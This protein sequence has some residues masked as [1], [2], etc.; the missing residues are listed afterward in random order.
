MR[1]YIATVILA[2]IA[3]AVVHRLF[4]AAADRYTII[5]VA[6]FAWSAWRV[7][8]AKRCAFRRV[9]AHLRSCDSAERDELLA[10]IEDLEL[11]AAARR[12]LNREHVETRNGS[13]EVFPFPRLFRTRATLRYWR[14]WGLSAAVLLIGAFVPGLDAISRGICLVL[15]LGLLVRAR[16]MAR[17]HTFVEAV[18]EIDP[19]HICC[20]WPDGRRDSVAFAEHHVLE[21]H[22]DQHVLYVRSRGAVVPVSYYLM[23]FRRLAALIEEYSGRAPVV[24]PPTN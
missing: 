1:P 20:I 12:E 10:S 17:R 19:F 4:G 21:D 14:D 13:V 6:G 8:R 18:V 11:R 9:M 22:T 23:G 5:V 15:G 3:A 2:A 16:V 7:Y 24:L